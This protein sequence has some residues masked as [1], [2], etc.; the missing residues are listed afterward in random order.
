M[1][2]LQ[3]HADMY[4]QYN[5]NLFQM[6]NM[7]TNQMSNE[8]KLLA[9]DMFY[10]SMHQLLYNETISST[11]TCALWR[12]ATQP[13]SQRK[14]SKAIS[15]YNAQP[16]HGQCLPGLYGDL[17]R[18]CKLDILHWRNR[19]TIY[20]WKLYYHIVSIIPTRIL[21]GHGL[22]LSHKLKASTRDKIMRSSESEWSLCA[23]TFREDERAFLLEPRQIE[24]VNMTGIYPN[25]SQFH[26]NKKR[27]QHL[28]DMNL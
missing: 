26:V 16:S 3:A 6:Y 8:M 25:S 11:T 14:D 21:A 23:I 27:S 5:M 17:M 19:Q 18:A 9:S 22:T 13:A 20:T 4:G 2:S 28:N 15:S 10:E 24:A 7:P 1:T 12:S